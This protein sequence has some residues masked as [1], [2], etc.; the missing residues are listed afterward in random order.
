MRQD[1]PSGI[2]LRRDSAPVPYR[3]KINQPGYVK[4]VAEEIA[5]LR[6]ISLEEVAAATTDTFLRLFPQTLTSLKPGKN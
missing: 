6:N 3:G 4:H 1:L 5:R 2:E